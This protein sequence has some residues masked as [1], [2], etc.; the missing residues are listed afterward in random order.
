MQGRAAGGPGAAPGRGGRAPGYPLGMRIAVHLLHASDEPE[1]AVAALALLRAAAE[2]G[3]APRLVLD[4]EGVRLAAKGVAAALRG[5]GRPDPATL[6]AAALAAGAR[7][8][9]VRDAW[10]A[11]G[12]ADD[13][14]VEGAVL[15]GPEDVA[16]LAA[17][18]VFVG[19]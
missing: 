16:A 19:Y 7:I 2:R 3:G 10:A 15:A 12:Y 8:L 6:L 1:H 14:L 17:D 13:A 9:V 4:L 18:H 5:D 11:R